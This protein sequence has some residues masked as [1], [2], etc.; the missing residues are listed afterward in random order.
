MSIPKKIEKEFYFFIICSNVIFQSCYA[1]LNLL[2][3]ETVI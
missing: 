1:F 2:K 3:W